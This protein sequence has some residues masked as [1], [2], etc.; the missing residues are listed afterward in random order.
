M[1]LLY[2]KYICKAISKFQKQAQATLY[3]CRPFSISILNTAI[4]RLPLT[5]HALVASQV[6]A[7]PL[8]KILLIISMGKTK[9]TVLLYSQSDTTFLEQESAFF[10]SVLSPDGLEDQMNQLKN[11]FHPFVFLRSFATP[12]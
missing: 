2:P 9:P 6:F 10:H 4:G 5:K 11:I 12:K 3:Y 7:A 8:S 1:S